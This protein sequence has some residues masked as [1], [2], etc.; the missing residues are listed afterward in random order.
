MPRFSGQRLRDLRGKRNQTDLAAGLQ[1]RGFGTTQTQISR[2]ESG[3]SPRRYILPALAAELGCQ[4][5]DLFEAADDEEDD[6]NAPL[7]RAV[8]R[9]VL[10]DEIRAALIEQRKGVKQ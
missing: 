1:R 2:W 7:T 4:V 3:Q 10:Q 6:L 5:G 9:A 8:L